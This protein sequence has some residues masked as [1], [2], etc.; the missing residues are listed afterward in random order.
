M[1]TL[2]EAARQALEALESA[3]MS[4]YGRD[5]V[6][7]DTAHPT[8]MAM[9]REAITALRQA[10][11]QAQKQEPVAGQPLPCPFC[12]HVG[13][14]FSDGNTY[15]W[16]IASCGGCGASCGDIRREYP[17]E[18]KWH[19]EAIAEWNR[20]AAPPPRQPLTWQ[21][22]ETA[23]KNGTDILVMYMHIDTQIVHNG[24]WMGEDDTDEEDDIGWWSYEHSEV[25]RIKLDD[26]MEPTHWLP[27]PA[28]GIKGEA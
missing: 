28:H 3:Q 21:P 23:P 7:P 2:I 26:W 9:V 22:I 11:E 12:G 13:L 14:D 24:F 25:S 27:L 10:I 16:G 15:R 20:R 8:A 17:D 5:W 4:N 19:S 18:G 6:W 1:T